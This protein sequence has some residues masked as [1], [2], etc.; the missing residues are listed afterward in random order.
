MGAG[1]AAVGFSVADREPEEV[2]RQYKEWL[3]R[4]DH[5]GMKWMERHAA[6]REDPAN[7]LP[8]AKTII[9]IAFA[10]EKYDGHD[11]SRP[12]IA[13]YAMGNDYHDVIREALRP[14]AERIEERYGC[15]CRICIDSAPIGERYRAVRSGIGVIGRNGCVIVK[16]AGSMVFLAEILTDLE[17]EPD[18][19]STGGCMMCGRC[20]RECPGSAIREDGTID[21]R[22]CISYLTIEHRGDWSGLML[23][24]MHGAGRQYLYGCDKCLRVCPHNNIAAEPPILAGLRPQ[25]EIISLRAES[26]PEMT[27]EEYNKTF[28]RSPIKRCKAEGLVRNALNCLGTDARHGDDADDADVTSRNPS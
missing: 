28:R 5:A 10:Y 2:G 4:G 13:S 23:E 27:W 6:L 15:R 25:S 3:G 14:V 1:A 11:P 16:G 20:I 12:I 18:D 19:A 17:I 9:S 21:S 24:T 8:G 7:V 22:R 26:I